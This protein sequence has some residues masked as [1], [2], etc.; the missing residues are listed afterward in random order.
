VQP[1][2]CAKP[3]L[4][5]HCDP[6]CRCLPSQSSVEMDE[7]VPSRGDE[8]PAL[9]HAVRLSEA[10]LR[11]CDWSFHPAPVRVVDQWFAPACQVQK[12]PGVQHAPA[13]ARAL[14]QL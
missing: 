3:L 1:R 6:L 13:D 9:T 7:H 14:M 5:P 10:L 8:G 12:W 2:D 11:N 4:L